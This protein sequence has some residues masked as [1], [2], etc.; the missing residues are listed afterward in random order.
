MGPNEIGEVAYKGP[1]PVMGYLKNPSQTMK[2]KDGEGYVFSGDMGFFDNFGN[3]T[4]V[5]RIKDIMKCDWHLV[6]PSEIECVINELD[7]VANS[8]VV[9]VDDGNCGDISNAFVKKKDHRLTEEDVINY[10]NCE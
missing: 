9:G 8:C 6:S 2:M 3:L 7:W 5:D 10:V 4:L 1:A